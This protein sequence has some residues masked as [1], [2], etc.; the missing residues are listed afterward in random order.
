[1][2]QMNLTS[3]EIDKVLNWFNCTWVGSFDD[4]PTEHCEL[5]DRFVDAFELARSA[6]LG[7]GRDYG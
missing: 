2:I 1:M 3:R 7:R 6:E 4:V 5:R